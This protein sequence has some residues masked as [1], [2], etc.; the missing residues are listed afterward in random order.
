MC[1]PGDNESSKPTSIDFAYLLSLSV[2]DRWEGARHQALEACNNAAKRLA[3]PGAGI[4]AKDAGIDH[5]VAQIGAAAL[6]SDSIEDVP[7]CAVCSD[8]A[9][10]ERFCVRIGVALQNLSVESAASAL[11]EF[12][13]AALSEKPNRH[14]EGIAL[15]ARAIIGV[16][17][18]RAHSSQEQNSQQPTTA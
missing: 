5:A 1:V 3:D 17:G 11:S 13:A 7:A 15:A 14:S 12:E 16:V 8:G 6:E 2:V 18:A 9:E 4:G 10:D